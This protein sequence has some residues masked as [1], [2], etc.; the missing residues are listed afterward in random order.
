MTHIHFSTN[1]N[2]VYKIKQKKLKT[3]FRQSNTPYQLTTQGIHSH[4]LNAIISLTYRNST[5]QIRHFLFFCFSKVLCDYIATHAES[6]NDNFCFWMS[7]TKMAEHVMEISCSPCKTQEIYYNMSNFKWQNT[8]VPSCKIFPS[9]FLINDLIEWEVKTYW[10]FQVM[11]IKFSSSF[12]LE[13]WKQIYPPAK[14]YSNWH[15]QTSVYI[16]SIV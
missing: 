7:L 3:Y 4:L 15:W 8:K 9:L 10:W 1:C 11:L 12:Y 13:C 14:N 2:K 6:N 5:Y 16:L